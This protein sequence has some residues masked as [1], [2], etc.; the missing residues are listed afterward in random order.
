M[1]FFWDSRLTESWHFHEQPVDVWSKRSSLRTLG[2]T[3]QV[4]QD[5]DLDHWNFFIWGF[6]SHQTQK[7]EDAVFL[8]VDVQK[9]FLWMVDGTKE[10]KLFESFRTGGVV[11]KWM[12]M[13]MI[14]SLSFSFQQTVSDRGNSWIWIR[15]ATTFQAR[16]G[17]GLA[18]Q[19][20]D[21]HL[22]SVVWGGARKT[23]D[24]TTSDCH[25]TFCIWLAWYLR[26]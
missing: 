4:S 24:V 9:R 1:Y 7:P 16:F 26:E 21:S 3:K 20:L 19:I 2:G 23:L 17:P 15:A 8:C 6:I 14:P 18:D 10:R 5:V 25:V 13:A 22:V 11:S 12:G